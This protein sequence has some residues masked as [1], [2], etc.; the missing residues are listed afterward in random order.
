MN[1]TL[2]VIIYSILFFILIIAFIWMGLYFD[3]NIKIN[4]TKIEELNNKIDSI[5]FKS[6]K[7]IDIKQ[8]SIQFIINLQ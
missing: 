1:N 8:D 6:I 7:S 5:N 2:T 3:T 4:E